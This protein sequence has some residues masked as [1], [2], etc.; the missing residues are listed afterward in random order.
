MEL[1]TKIIGLGNEILT[2]DGIGSRI[3]NDLEE[4]L[5]DHGID[6]YT[7]PDGS[8]DML[9]EIRGYD[10]L[11]MIDANFTAGKTPGD[12]CF[13]SYPLK[14]PTLHLSGLH[15]VGFNDMISL[16]RELKMKVPDNIGI[17]S[18]EIEEFKVFS[19]NFSGNLQLRYPDILELVKNYIKNFIESNCQGKITEEVENENI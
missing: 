10:K 2:D 4:F 12:I 16:S 7:T 19:R 18:V 9:E 17:I 6:H 8:L 5:I 3:V 1:K 15:D 11:I 13:L 14:E